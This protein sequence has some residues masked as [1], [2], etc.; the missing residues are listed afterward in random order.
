MKL[1]YIRF[2][3]I[4]V[5]LINKIFRYFAKIFNIF[6]NNMRTFIKFAVI[7]LMFALPHSVYGQ[8]FQNDME[9][10][11]R[12]NTFLLGYSVGSSNG[13]LSSKKVNEKIKKN[14][15]NIYLCKK[16]KK[17]THVYDNKT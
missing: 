10:Q 14:K 17:C 11:A 9:Y 7:I 12:N 8:P 2:F 13:Q 5:W 16:N 15:K 4:F 1:N 3:T 6:F